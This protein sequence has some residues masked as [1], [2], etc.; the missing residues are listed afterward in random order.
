MSSIPLQFL[1]ITRP[2]SGCGLSFCL[3]C[4]S[5][6]FVFNASKIYLVVYHA[7]LFVWFSF[8]QSAPVKNYHSLPSARSICINYRPSVVLPVD[9][10]P[11]NKMHENLGGY[12]D[13]SAAKEALPTLTLGMSV[14]VIG[15]DG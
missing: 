11:D 14:L 9:G 8:R 3:A 10:K 13:C 1:S 12:L 2:L 6:S 4:S 5:S 7:A 15:I